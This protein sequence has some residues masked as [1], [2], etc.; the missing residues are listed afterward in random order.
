M[1]VAAGVI[2]VVVAEGTVLVLLGEVDEVVFT[3][4]EVAISW[5]PVHADMTSKVE[6]S[7]RRME[8]KVMSRLRQP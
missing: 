1:V 6:T 2:V 8:R 4:L 3:E 5:A 7:P